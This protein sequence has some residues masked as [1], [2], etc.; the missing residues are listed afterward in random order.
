MR[1]DAHVHLFDPARFPY[2]ANTIHRPTEEDTATLDDLFSVM[3]RHAISHAVLVGPMAG[4]GPDNR[5]L[6]DGLARGGE[7]VRGMAILEPSVTDAELDALTAGGVV[8]AR[9]DL[10]TFGA[11][12]LAGPAKALLARLAARDWLVEIQAQ[13]ADFATIGREIAGFPGR[14]VIDHAGRPDPAEGMLQRGLTN[15]LGLAQGGRTWVKLSGPFRES[16]EAAP[17]ADM[18]PFFRAVATAFGPERCVWGSDWPFVRS[19]W[20]P[21]YAETLDALTSWVPDRRARNRLLG[22]TARDLFGFRS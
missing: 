14:V 7:R 3:D 6:L 9:F 13:A 22:P 1:C 16:R 19:A 2:A 10:L 5:C 8:G 18:D 15:L 17:F 21:P 11:T 4:Y 20:R 12:Y